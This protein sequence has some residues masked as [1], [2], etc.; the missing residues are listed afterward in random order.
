MDQGICLQIYWKTDLKFINA[1][2]CTEI[3]HKKQ[4]QLLI[5]LITPENIHLLQN[6]KILFSDQ[7]NYREFWAR[8]WDWA[9]IGSVLTKPTTTKSTQ[10]EVFRWQPNFV[11]KCVRQSQL[12]STFYR[13]NPC[14][15]WQ[16]EA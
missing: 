15:T 7:K 12:K 13:T 1:R 8:L 14:S 3:D 10:F 11:S 6:S 5:I 9:I 16:D 2:N 4:I